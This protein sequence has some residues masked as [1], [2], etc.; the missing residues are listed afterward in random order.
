[1]PMTDQ[2]ISAFRRYRARGYGATEAKALAL[3]WIAQGKAYYDLPDR[4][5]YIGAPNSKGERWIDNLESAGLRFVGFADK[6]LDLR[7]SGYFTNCHGDGD[8]LRGAVY[9]LPA[10]KGRVRYV[11]AYREG[12]QERGRNWQD[13]AGP[14]GALLAL[15]DIRLGDIPAPNCFESCDESAKRDAAMTGDSMAENAAES[16]REY[17]SAWQ[18]G[19]EFADLMESAQA[20]R[21]KARALVADIRGARAD[22]GFCDRFPSIGA[23]LRNAIR[24]SLETWRDDRAKASELRANWESPALSYASHSWKIRKLELAQAFAGGAGL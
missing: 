2:E 23:A 10:R 17:D 4:R 8:V 15:G 14:H 1:M 24:D 16:A 21:S 19:Q 12:S 22:S 3:R 11:P 7:H 6:I 18:A 13:T 5:A 20:A 9:Q